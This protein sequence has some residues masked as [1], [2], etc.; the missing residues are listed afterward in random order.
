MTVLST[1]IRGL[2]TIAFGTLLAVAPAASKEFSYSARQNDRLA[3]KLNIP[4][5][6]TLPAS[7]RGAVPSD[8]NTTDLLVDFKHPD[9]KP[10]QNVGLRLVLTKRAG[11]AQRLAK[12]GLIQ[13]GDIL[14]TFRSEWA[15][16]GPYPNIQMGI[17]HTGVAY[18][19][20][21]FVHNIDNPLNEEYLGAGMRADLTSEHYRTLDYLHVIRP[22]YLTD[23]QK[24]NLVAWASRLNSSARSV[25]PAKLSFNQDYNAP[26]FRHGKSPTFV[27]Q[28]AQ[29]ALGQDSGSN[30]GMFCSEF[31]WSLLSLRNCDPAKTADQFKSASMPVC[32]N[33]PMKPMYATGDYIF[34]KS[35]S[36]YTGLAD[37]PLLIIDALKLPADERKKML[38]SVFVENPAG[39][40][41]MSIGH[42]TVATEMKPKFEPLKQYYEGA[43]G[44]LF[45]SLKTRIATKIFT[46]DIP[47]NY[48]PT[49]FLINTLLPTD[50]VNRT[51]DYIATIVIE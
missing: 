16:A 46:R 49:S 10:D 24:A 23:E 29:M 37:G 40:Q 30:V 7:A 2:T 26:K 38:D 21:G 32:V 44:G 51:M 13:T 47:E 4:I 27:Q 50:N 19:K 9:A 15:G 1:A 8:I 5:Y 17:S 22:R 12:S 35:K 34:S 48:S 11:M 18:V 33:Q 39:M 3:K 45:S 28:L 20:D 36:S 25:Y 43:T 41:K 14:L 42:R 6:F 31:A